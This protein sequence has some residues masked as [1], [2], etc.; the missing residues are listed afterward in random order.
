MA[1]RILS[2][3]KLA[4]HPKFQAILTEF[5]SRLQ[6]SPKRRV[7]ATRFFHEVIAPEIP[8]YSITAW[9]EFLRRFKTTAGLADA[10][11]V[12]PNITTVPGTPAENDLIASLLTNQEATQ[13]GI[14]HALNLGAKYFQDLMKKYTENPSTLTTSENK[15]LAEALFKAMKS[16]DSRI[17]ALGKIRED[18]R[19]QEKFDRAFSDVAGSE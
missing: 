17:H 4:T 19:E 18:T 13:R 8:D 9:R 15:V 10:I 16:Q 2:T 6:A 3:N 11:L 7:N 1:V 12:R 5:N 14:A